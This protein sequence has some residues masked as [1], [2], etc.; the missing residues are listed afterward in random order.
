[1]PVGVGEVVV[2]VEEWR[3]VKEG[4]VAALYG[5]R[6]YLWDLVQ[7]FPEQRGLRQGCKVR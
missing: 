6:H 1:M 2:G 5:R 4:A 3:D 7:E